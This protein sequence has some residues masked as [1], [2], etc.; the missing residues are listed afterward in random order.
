[1]ANAN[2]AAKSTTQDMQQLSEQIGNLKNEIADISRTLGNLG[3]HTREAARNEIE[4]SVAQFRKRGA[5]SLE[6]AQTTAEDLGQAAAE[7]V[8]KQPA[9]AVGM[10]VGV[11]F[12]LGF[13]TGRK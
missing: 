13:L 4:N 3:T 6:K 12:L 5:E 10:A 2:A 7:S 11:G 8:R 1:M 9:A